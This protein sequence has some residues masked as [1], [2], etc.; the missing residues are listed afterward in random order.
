MPRALAADVGGTAPRGSVPDLA[1]L[2]R[3][4]AVW[5]VA[6]GEQL[7]LIA[8]PVRITGDGTL[9]VHARDASWTHALTLEERRILARLAELL[10]DDA[11]RALKVEVGVIATPAEAQPVASP[12]PLSAEARRRAEELTRDVADPRLRDGLRRLVAQ[13]LERRKS[14]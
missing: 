1:P 10:G 13:S 2:R 4:A 9:V 12:E 6:V 8:Q 3:I 14:S 5:P 7:A 11:P